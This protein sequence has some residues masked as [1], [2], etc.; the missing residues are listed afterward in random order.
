MQPP[1]SFSGFCGLASDLHAEE[2]EQPD[3][4]PVLGLP[5]HAGARMCVRITNVRRQI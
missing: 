3:T 2:P 1:K 4:Q 5:A